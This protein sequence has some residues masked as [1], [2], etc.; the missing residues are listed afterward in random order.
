[1][2]P[3][4]LSIVDRFP[5]LQSIRLHAG[6]DIIGASA[7]DEPLGVAAE[8][9]KPRSRGPFATLMSAQD[10]GDA[11]IEAASTSAVAALA[12]TP[13]ITPEDRIAVDRPTAGL[14]LD[15][16][17]LIRSAVEAQ[18]TAETDLSPGRPSGRGALDLPV[19]LRVLPV[20]GP[21]AT[22]VAAREPSLSETVGRLPKVR[23]R[24][25]LRW[26]AN[27]SVVPDVPDFLVAAKAPADAISVSPGPA[28]TAPSTDRP[29]ARDPAAT[30]RRSFGALS[31]AE[32]GVQNRRPV[33]PGRR[34][35]PGVSADS[36]IPPL[37]NA[38]GAGTA[39]P[40]LSFVG[41]TPAA[42]KPQTLNPA[43]RVLQ[44]P[45]GTAAPLRQI[46]GE[47][48]DRPARS[49][50]APAAVATTGG[51]AFAD[52][53]LSAGGP[54]P[55]TADDGALEGTAFLHQPVGTE[56][57]Q[58]E[59]SA[60]LSVMAEQGEYAEA[61]MKLA[62]AELGELEIRIE[63]R[64]SEAALQFGAAS[65]ETRQALELAQSRLREMMTGQGISVSEFSIFNDL[66]NNADGNSR[67]MKERPSPNG[68]PHRVTLGT[69][70]DLE[71]TPG[72]RR[73]VGLVD[74]YA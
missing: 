50:Q 73:V 35:E 38:P 69:A 23:S 71:G 18:A 7:Q 65:V 25:E 63:L 8:S 28:F 6:T 44:D 37:R 45:T 36:G 5:E 30:L 52:P 34:I 33:E 2:T 22:V 31:G 43:H 51:P 53:S 1:M 48:T 55:S 66:S 32:L 27:P 57:W 10:L 47:W 70:V 15:S 13:T 49:A 42:M 26:V 46:V 19:F 58:D 3:K 40:S 68:A 62:P 20:S 72:D 4:N 39:L 14:E 54:S 16:S 61:V 29:T 21:G 64:G 24:D 59:L 17:Q 74:L 67:S 11:S 9:G 56:A 60:Q 12:V 41:I